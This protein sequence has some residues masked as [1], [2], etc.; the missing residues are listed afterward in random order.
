[1]SREAS[2]KVCGDATSESKTGFE[3]QAKLFGLD[4]EVSKKGFK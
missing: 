2:L 1:M 3:F 4:P